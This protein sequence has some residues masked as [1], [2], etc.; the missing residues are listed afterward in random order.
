M[1]RGECIFGDF[2]ELRVFGE[3]LE[4]RA[5]L[6]QARPCC[7]ADGEGAP[8][9]RTGARDFGEHEVDRATVAEPDERDQRGG[10]LAR[11][12]EAG[13]QAER[14]GGGER[15]RALHAELTSELEN[16]LDS[17]RIALFEL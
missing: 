5:C 17:P 13:A 16:G 11:I 14:G 9:E 12:A 7:D 4:V 8:L 2:A 15:N 10:A 1:K 3:L 6:V